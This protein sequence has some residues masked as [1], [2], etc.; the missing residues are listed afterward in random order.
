MSERLKG[1]GSLENILHIKKVGGD[2]KMEGK[3]IKGG[4]GSQVEEEE[5]D[6]W[7]SP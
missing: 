7:G 5:A 3:G 1:E 2:P 6:S 4:G